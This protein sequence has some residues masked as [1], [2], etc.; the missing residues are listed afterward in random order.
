[1]PNLKIDTS[2]KSHKEQTSPT[3]I[4]RISPSPLNQ[5]RK[6][7][8]HSTVEDDAASD[9]SSVG[10]SKPQIQQSTLFNNFSPRSSLDLRETDRSAFLNVRRPS[11]SK[12]L[13]RSPLSRS[14][15]DH[16]TE[17]LMMGYAQ[18]Q[19]NLMID[20]A[21]INTSEFEDIK[22]RGV[23]GGK[24]GG[25]VVGLD[26][27]KSAPWTGLNALT[28]LNIGS[29]FGLNQPSSI[30]EM[31]DRASS[32][33]IP[34]LSTPP[35]ILFI[36]I[37]LA[38]GEARA[39]TYSF[40]LPRELPPSHRGRALRISYSLLITTQRPGQSGQQLSTAEIPFRLFST[41]DGMGYFG[42]TNVEYGHQPRYNLKSP[43]ILLRDQARTSS[44]T[45]T[46]EPSPEKSTVP[47]PRTGRRSSTYSDKPIESSQEEFMKFVDKLLS[48]LGRVPMSAT[49]S[50]LH[51]DVPR[52][53]SPTPT[54]ERTSKLTCREAIDVLLKK[55]SKV[56]VFEIGK[57][58]VTVA[59]LTLPRTTYKLG[60]TVEGVLD[61]SGGP[62]KCYQVVSV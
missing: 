9:T 47:R 16:Y 17:N 42:D 11:Q 59:K 25:G 60:E 20:E 56:G 15:T 49:E 61:F 1:L 44:V 8:L 6:L 35:S 39:F 28:N 32:K 38:P 31:R 29:I 36:D 23:V 26:N 7:D 45:D 52:T 4:E 41:V 53:P 51:L 55:R 62:I 54:R 18:I 19:G 34:V 24:S 50:S 14:N 13:P 3:E 37:R 22:S 43:V 2:G 5:I 40:K 10:P 57:N 27:R 48:S 46:R 21:L 58:G 30:A 33:A 12:R